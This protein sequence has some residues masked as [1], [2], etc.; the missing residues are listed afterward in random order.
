[1]ADK[2]QEQVLFASDSVSATAPR[3]LVTYAASNSGMPMWVWIIVVVV[4]AIIAFFA[5]LAITRRNARKAA[6]DNELPLD[7]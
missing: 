2:S 7:K 3:L 4:I 6:S 5:G 1:M